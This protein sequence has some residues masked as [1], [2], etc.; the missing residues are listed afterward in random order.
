MDLILHIIA[1][2]TVVVAGSY[3][4]I[5]GQ[6]V[7]EDRLYKKFVARLEEEGRI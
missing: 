4:S 2:I 5:L 6:R 7:Y 1:L 3:L